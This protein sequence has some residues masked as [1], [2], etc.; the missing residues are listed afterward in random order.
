M[1]LPVAF[2]TADEFAETQAEVDTVTIEPE[3][4]RLTLLAKA[5]TALPSGPQ[6]LSRIVI[7]EMSDAIRESVET[8][9]GP[10]AE[11]RIAVSR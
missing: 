2:V 9:G 10:P 4:R 5:Q 6:S 7:G 8:G 11:A 3:E 1:H